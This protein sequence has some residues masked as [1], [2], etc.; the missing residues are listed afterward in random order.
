LWFTSSPTGTT[1]APSGFVTLH[2]ALV[3]TTGV[4]TMIK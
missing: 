2:I 4:I 3:L 1:L